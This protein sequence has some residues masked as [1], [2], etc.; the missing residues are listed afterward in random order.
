MSSIDLTDAVLN[1]NTPWVACAAIEELFRSGLQCK[2]SDSRNWAGMAFTCA[3]K[4]EKECETPSH[5]DRALAWAHLAVSIRESLASSYSAAESVGI[6][7]GA[8]WVRAH[9]IV[10]CGNH[11]GD[12]LCDSHKVVNWCLEVPQVRDFLELENI[13]AFD[14]LEPEVRDV[15]DM[16]TTLIAASRFEEAGVVAD[17]MASIRQAKLVAQSRPSDAE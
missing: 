14:S 5:I 1:R 2:V 13:P 4:A 17:F 7:A 10:R 9:M 3:M 11:P 12:P 15:A 16:L 6:V 8:M